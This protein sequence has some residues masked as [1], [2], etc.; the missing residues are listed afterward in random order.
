GLCYSVSAGYKGD[1]DF[2]GVTAYV[3]TTP[4]RA[5]ESL[6]VLLAEL[7]RIQNEA[8]AVTKEEFSRAIV[9][10]KSRLVFSGE[11]SAARALAIGADFFRLGRC[12]TLEELSR[13][14]D[15]VTLERVNE[16]LG[17]R[18]LGRTTIQTVGPAPLTPPAS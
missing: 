18:Q 10:M 2:G 6:D 14:V 8:G 9:G 5:Q 11:S 13:E 12:R 1:R 3:G 7:R 15:A 17:R 16:Y 4:Q